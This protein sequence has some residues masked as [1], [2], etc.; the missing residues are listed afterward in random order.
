MINRSIFEKVK[1]KLSRKVK[2]LKFFAG[3][4]VFRIKG[5][6]VV[7]E[8]DVLLVFCPPWD[9]YMPPLGISYL[10]STLGKLNFEVLIF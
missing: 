9:V 2:R 7:K 1:S 6:P 3:E 8:P 5:A 4:E 10:A